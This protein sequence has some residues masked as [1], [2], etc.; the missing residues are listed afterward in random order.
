MK[1]VIGN[2]TI[3]I[4]SEIDPATKKADR[5]KVVQ[6]MCGLFRDAGAAMKAD[7]EKHETPKE[8]EQRIL[9]EKLTDATDQA[10][11]V[12]LARMQEML[13]GPQR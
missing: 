9:N 10:K 2:G 5:D 4:E 6:S 1:I 11:K 8:R 13:R 7:Y 12:E 3:A